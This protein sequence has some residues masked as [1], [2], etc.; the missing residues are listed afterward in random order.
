MCPSR[1]CHSLAALFLASS[2]ASTARAQETV[3]DVETYIAPRPLERANPA[4]PSR[5]LAERKEGWV[6]LSFVVSPTGTVTEPMIEDSS[7]SEAFEN[8]ALRA[9]ERWKYSPATQ[10]GQPVEHA[11][12]KSRIT[13]Q[14][15]DNTDG[16]TPAALRKFRR[17]GSLIE[18]RNFAEAEPLIAE[19]EFGERST[20]YED[21]WFWWIK[22][23]YL[24]TSGS[25]DEAEMRKS[26][27]RAI[28]YEEEYLSA[29]NYVAAARNLFVFDAKALDV[30]G[31]IW[32]FEKLRDAKT[33]R[34]ADTYDEAMQVLTPVYE[35]LL[36]I[37]GGND[38][39]VTEGRVGEYDYWVH[40]LV[41]RSFALA[42][43]AGRIDVLDIRCERGT[44]RYN[45]IPADSIWTIPESWGSCGVYIKGEPGATFAF[46][47]YSASYVTEPT[48]DV[49]QPGDSP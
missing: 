33:A 44:K 23:V 24:Q 34:R 5:A 29:T 41:R 38:V 4:Y 32:A 28:G 1:S 21:A 31:A 2:L 37:V 12:T 43:V 17:I 14:L 36:Q 47:E 10:D 16:V 26:L 45:S 39:L 42:D 8:A 30:S 6:I 11:M 19:M 15:Q 7:G 46:R 49:S 13:F 3:P 27:R 22:Y 40:D 25:T 9:I 20:L 18:E 35:Q 48:V